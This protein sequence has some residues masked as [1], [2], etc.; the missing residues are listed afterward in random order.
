MND[1]QRRES[2]A[3]RYAR[4]VIR[5]RVPIILATVVA[6]VVAASGARFLYFSQDYRVFFSKQNPQLEAFEALQ[7]IYTQSDN[8]F[9]V[10]D[11]PDGEAFS[12]ETLSAIEDLT[13]AAWKI[14][15]AIRVDAVTNFQHTR[16]EG[17]DLIVEDLVSDARNLPADVLEARE[18]IALAEP[19]LYQQLIGPEADVSAVNVTLQ[20]PRLSQDEQ[21]RTVE[22]ARA[23][24]A[25]I[26]AD[27]PG[28]EVYITGMAMLNIAFQEASQKDMTSL[29]PIMFLAILVVMGLMLRSVTGTAVTF[30]IIGLSV[31]TAM[32]LAGWLGMGITP[33]SASAPTM[34]MTLAVADSI[35]ILVTMLREMRL[36]LTKRDALIESIRVN[37]QPVF[38]TSLTTAIGFLSMNLS[39]APPFHDLGNITAMGVGAAFI[40]SV[41]LLPALASVLPFRVTTQAE[42][43]HPWADRLG[44][45]VVR[46]R[47]ALLW[48]SAVVVLVLAALVPKNELNDQFVEYFDE[49]IQFR[50][51][52]DFAT[53]HLSGLYR[54]EFSLAAGESGGISDP[55]YLQTIDAFANWYLEQPNVLH[56]STLSNTMKRLNKS[57]HGD[58]PAYYRLPDSRELAAQFLLL[59]EM[60]LPYG[61]DLNNQINVDKSATRFIVTLTDVSTKQIQATTSAGE[62]WLEDHAPAT[63]RTRAA[64]TAIMFASITQRNIRSMLNGTLLAFVFV[65]LAL[66]AALKSFRYGLLSL[67]PNLVPA[68]MAFGVWGLLVGQVNVGLSIVVAMTFG[69]VV[70]DSV[71]FLSKYVRARREEHLDAESAVRHAFH[72][73]GPALVA[74]TIVMA[75]G[76]AILAFSAFD[77]NAGMGRLT[78]I[79][80]VM[81]LAADFF[82]LPPLLM[83][84]DRKVPTTAS[85]L[86]PNTGEHDEVLVTA[87]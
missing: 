68:A 19:A 64:S 20:F 54:L 77:M 27:Y 30:V 6:A 63:M 59:Y 56:V 80:V 46:R 53:E 67:I 42:S 78:A 55:E 43:R 5:W 66:I 24:A 85:T 15:F 29:I 48:G 83:W 76:F 9:F 28:V 25:R 65:S 22:G 57:M 61:M 75:T 62:T 86:I 74:T 36:G 11:P 2:F 1:Q 32:G 58:D 60:S 34:I 8:V 47:R 33:P 40:F 82:L 10:V 18:A 13:A 44:E 26:E 45:F 72:S 3:G 71:H 79:T 31:G 51:D 41:L 69:I 37:L 35:H 23:L 50:T 87:G 21:M 39:D 52:T 81:A 70:D 17:D 49:S 84:L 12:A 73:V 4:W 7:N 38:L 16:A 14:P